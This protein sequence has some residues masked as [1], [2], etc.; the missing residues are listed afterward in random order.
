MEH[1][2]KKDGHEEWERESDV[3]ELGGG[4]VGKETD[5]PVGALDVR[6]D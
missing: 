4:P 1:A 6:V 3:G 2:V 5:V